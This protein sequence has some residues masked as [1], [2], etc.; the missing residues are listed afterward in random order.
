MLVGEA[1]GKD[2]DSLREFFVGKTGKELTNYLS[3]V[4]I[5]RERVYIT[6]ILKCRTNADNRDPKA[7]EIACC[8]VLLL[9][10]IEEVK[11]RFVVAAGRISARWFLGDV[12]M[13]QVH[14]IPFQLGPERFG[15]PM[16]VIPI[17]HPASGL[18]ESTNMSVIMADFQDVKHTL[19]GKIKPWMP[20]QAAGCEYRYEVWGGNEDDLGDIIAIDT[21]TEEHDKAWS[22]QFSSEPGV[23]LFIPVTDNANILKLGHHVANPEVHTI[24]HNAMFDIPVLES[25]GIRPVRYTDTMVMAYLLQTEPQGLKSLAFR[26]LGLRMN[27]YEDMVNP[28]TQEMAIEYL[29]RVSDLI[30]PKV[31]PVAEI[32]GTEVKMRQPQTL[33]TR[34]K[35]ILND[36]EKGGDVDAFARWMMVK[37]EEGRDMA[38]AFLGPMR[39]AYLKDIEFDRALRYACQDPDATLQ[40]YFTL[41]DK[42]Q[43]LGLDDVLDRDMR[44]LPMVANMQSNGMKVDL[45]YLATLSK[46]FEG[47][48][49]E[50]L[51]MIYGMVGDLNPGSDLQ[52]FDLLRRIGL[53]RRPK[54]YK[55]ATDHAK[56]ESLIGRHPVIEPIVQWRGYKKL[57]S[58]FLDV[59]PTKTAEDGRVR[60]TLRITRVVTGRLSSSN[61]N[62]MAQPVRTEDGRKIRGGFVAAD[63]FSLLSGDY[64]QVEMRGVAHMSQDP[65]M[66]DIFVK[67]K[68]IHAETASMMFNIPVGELDEMQ[69][70]YPAK[71]VGFGILNLISARKLLREMEVGG[72][73]GWTEARC[74]DMIY[75]WFAVYQ[76]VRDWIEEQKNFARRHGFVRDMWG[77]I[78]LSPELLSVHQSVIEAGIRQ[79]VNAP[80]QMSAQGI[81]KEAMGQLV[82]IYKGLGGLVRPLLQIHDDLLWEIQDDMI[83]AVLPILRDV[84]EGA[85]PFMLVPLKVD[86]K[87]GK[88]WDSMEKV[89]WIK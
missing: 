28:R 51:E 75:N 23:G 84:M 21:E 33:N 24:I 76:G 2:E 1:P 52:V 38:E 25:V 67:N 68:D 81:I 63:G 88:R 12:N 37:P 41:A 78:R 14:G 59:I 89:I 77:R 30:W 26:Y 32:K 69:H 48:M 49:D 71:R 6:N 20:P 53:E 16:V 55:G 42:I 85:A 74:Q 5:P 22:I 56:M 35:K 57:K 86:F 62:L 72:A 15:Y 40:I 29:R 45:P 54:M 44:M 11:P 10:E 39:E 8:E 80:I 4:G 73:K 46:E 65:T 36:I 58:S 79:S 61:P 43:A 19:M 50:L 87:V 83:P 64:S 82:P 60:T 27:E 7:S 34:V 17:L 18:H 66:I 13:D 70:R 31:N 47:R 3:R 9:Q